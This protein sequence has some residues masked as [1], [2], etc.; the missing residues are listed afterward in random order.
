MV[1]RRSLEPPSLSPLGF[2]RVVRHFE[3]R[4]VD[5]RRLVEAGAL[6]SGVG[7]NSV[8]QIVNL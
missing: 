5:A 4:I 6:T 8:S 1:R 2:P 3:E 7:G